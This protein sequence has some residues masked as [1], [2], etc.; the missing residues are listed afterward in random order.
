VENKEGKEA[1]PE[2]RAEPNKAEIANAGVP[3]V[4]LIN[5]GSASASEI[6]SGS[7]QAHGAAVIVGTRSF[8]KGSVQTV[9]NIRGS[10]AL[11]K[12]TPQYYRL[13][14]S[15]EE[16]ARGEPGRIVHKRPGAV[17][18]G[19]DPDVEVP[20][21]PQEI[22]AAYDLRQD[23]DIVDPKAGVRPDINGLIT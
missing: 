7:L 11:L 9:H 14:A 16:A 12:L 21:T 23:A 6:V 5:E 17:R 1:L 19:V 3:T 8:G 13:P 2:R 15:A 22:K 20:T 18:W 4:V 10:N